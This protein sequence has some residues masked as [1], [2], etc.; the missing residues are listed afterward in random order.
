MRLID[1]RHAIVDVPSHLDLRKPQFLPHWLHQWLLLQ[2]KRLV[3]DAPHSREQ[4]RNLL[5][6]FP[7]CLETSELRDML[8]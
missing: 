3:N 5:E 6:K 4:G 1:L 7:A 8:F 2:T